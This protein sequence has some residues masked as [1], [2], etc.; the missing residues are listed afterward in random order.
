MAVGAL[1]PRFYAALLAGL[2]LTEAPDRGDP[3]DWPR[4]R[5]LFTARFAETRDEWAAA[6]ASSEACVEPVL[7]MREPP[8][9]STWP[10]G[11]TNV[12]GT[13]SSSPRPRRASPGR[14][15]C[16]APS[17]PGRRPTETLTT[18]AC[19]TRPGS[20]PPAPPSC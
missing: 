18:G 12:S 11:G 7:S 15:D 13:A 16:P 1:E 2:G 17:V 19:P 4:L 3:G 9:T 20:S 5:K 8:P 6:F 14:R 10:R